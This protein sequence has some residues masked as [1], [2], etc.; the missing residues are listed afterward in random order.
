[1][2]ELS[3]KT[4]NTK[5]NIKMQSMKV[6]RSGRKVKEPKRFQNEQFTDNLISNNEYI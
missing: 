4:Y 2:I 5:D 6:T 3:Y 1:M